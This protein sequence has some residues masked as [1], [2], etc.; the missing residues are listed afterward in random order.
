MLGTTVC[1]ASSVEDAL[2]VFVLSAV[3]FESPGSEQAVIAMTSQS[4]EMTRNLPERAQ[5]RCERVGGRLSF[6]PFL[7]W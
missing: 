2:G 6:I 5:G 7:Y 4:V 3:G 1:V